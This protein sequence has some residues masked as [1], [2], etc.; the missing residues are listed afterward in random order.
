MFVKITY[1]DSQLGSETCSSITHYLDIKSVIVNN[2]LNSC[3]VQLSRDFMLSIDHAQDVNTFVSALESG[4][5]VFDFSNLSDQSAAYNN[6]GD[7]LN[8]C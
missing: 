7:K 8:C 1:N 3:V 4:V 2:S 6:Y 5:A